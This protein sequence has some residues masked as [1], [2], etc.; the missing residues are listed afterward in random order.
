[1]TDARI[2]TPFLRVV[3][4]SVVSKKFTLERCSPGVKTFVGWLEFFNI[5]RASFATRRKKS[6]KSGPRANYAWKEMYADNSLQGI[7]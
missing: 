3:R 4:E 7:F 6:K 1:V 5:Y 2:N